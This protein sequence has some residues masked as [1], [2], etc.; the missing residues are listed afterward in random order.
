MQRGGKDHS[1]SDEAAMGTEVLK[2]RNNWVTSPRKKREASSSLSPKAPAAKNGDLTMLPQGLQALSSVTSPKGNITSDA[3]P[4]SPR[5]YKCEPVAP[6]LTERS[7]PSKGS[8][9]PRG[10][11]LTARGP[12]GGSSGMQPAPPGKTGPVSRMPP[13]SHDSG[14]SMSPSAKTPRMPSNLGVAP[15]APAVPGTPSGGSVFARRL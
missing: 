5:D 1:Q 9:G 14:S 13:P 7:S 11:S 4:L 15:P 6:P 10:G 8:S 2:R 12:H 3:L